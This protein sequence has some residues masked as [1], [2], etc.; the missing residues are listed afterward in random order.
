MRFGIKFPRIFY[1]WWI[2]LACFMIALYTAGV[3]GY[4]FTAVFEPIVS[5]FGWSY[6][7]VSL[8]SSLRGLEVGLF[9][10]LVG[11]L[12]DRFGAK[13]VI[14]VGGIITG[15]SLMLLART[16]SLVMFYVSFALVSLGMSACSATALLVAVSYWF[17]RRIG[18]AMGIMVCG[19][20][21]SGFIVPTVVWMVDTLGWRTALT[22]FGVG[23]FL[24]ILPLSLAVRGRPEKYGLLPDGDVSIPA[25]SGSNVSPAKTEGKNISAR[26]IFTSRTF[27]HIALAFSAQH[28]IVGAV[29]T[30]IMPYLGSVGID[31]ALAGV[32]TTFVPLASIVGRFGFGWLSDR[33]KNKR[34]AVAGFAL[35]GLGMFFLS[36]ASPGA[37]WVLVL[38]LFFFGI[39]FGGTNTMRAILP[40]EY[41][42]MKNFGTILGFLT[43]VGTLGSMSGAPLARFCYDKFGSYQ[44]IWLIFIGVAA[45][46]LISILLT[47]PFTA[48]GVKSPEKKA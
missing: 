48:K 42:G 41:F 2:V 14:F 7:Q 46:S 45:F 44:P 24:I 11:L 38:F 18:T 31:R 47:P 36:Y 32:V 34:L 9:A 3:I 26:V 8:A 17:R 37:M 5:E 1:G 33:M 20:G 12:L 13:P 19:F 23:M 35:M 10:P 15:F 29:I 43:G 40:R 6:T 27:W 22:Y 28:M 4:G 30:H 25:S 39:G 21:C 16:N